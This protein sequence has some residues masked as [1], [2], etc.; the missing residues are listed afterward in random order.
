[1]PFETLLSAIHSPDSA[2]QIRKS[3]R[4]RAEQLLDLLGCLVRVDADEEEYEWV[5][6]GDDYHCEEHDKHSLGFISLAHYTIGEFLSSPRIGRSSVVSF[7]PWERS[8]FFRTVLLQALQVNFNSDT[9]VPHDCNFSHYVVFTAFAMIAQWGNQIADNA[10]LAELAF[11]Y[12]KPD[13]SHWGAVEMSLKAVEGAIISCEIADNLSSFWL[14][15][16][17]PHVQVTPT[18]QAAYT[19]MC[20]LDLQQWDLASALLSVFSKR[21]VSDTEDTV[22]LTRISWTIAISAYRDISETHPDSQVQYAFEGT[23]PAWAATFAAVG[24]N[25]SN[26]AKPFEFLFHNYSASFV[27]QTSGILVPIVF[28]H[29]DFH[30]LDEVS[31]AP[32]HWSRGGCGPQRCVIAQAIDCGASLEAPEYQ[33]TPLQVAVR[34]CDYRAVKLLLAAG[35]NVNNTGAARETAFSTKSPLSLFNSLH[36]ASPLYICRRILRPGISAMIFAEFGHVLP[37]DDYGGSSNPVDIERLLLEYGG[38]EFRA[39][40]PHPA[41]DCEIPDDELSMFI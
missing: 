24:S 8:V 29:T 39:L 38:E 27:R 4:L 11:N 12:F 35:A 34:R 20:L 31:N 6:D 37:E 5:E 25:Q 10:D 17:T 23:L 15:K 36:G 9:Y 14:S 32:R 7:S 28:A 13:A 18:I 21:S 19:L 41:T 33:V 26:N 40:T 2:N 30:V 22:L 1:M 16:L 3:L